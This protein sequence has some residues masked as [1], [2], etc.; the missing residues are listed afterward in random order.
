MA[1]AIAVAR[2]GG[3]VGYVGVPHGP[4]EETLDIMRLFFNNLTLHGGRRPFAPTWKSS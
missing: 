2:P 4:A 3:A 1:P